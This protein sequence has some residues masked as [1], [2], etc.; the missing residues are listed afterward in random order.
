MPTEMV[1]GLLGEA[2]SV[3]NALNGRG[4]LVLGQDLTFAASVWTSL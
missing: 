2:V 3:G 1:F 4:G